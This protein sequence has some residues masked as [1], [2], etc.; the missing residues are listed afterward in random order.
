MS[1]LC[2]SLN[3]YCC[4]KTPQ[5]CEL[6][7]KNFFLAMINPQKRRNFSRWTQQNTENYYFFV[8]I[9]FLDFYFR[10]FTF[11]A[12]KNFFLELFFFY[13]IKSYIALPVCKTGKLFFFSLWLACSFS[14][15]FYVHSMKTFM[16]YK[17]NFIKS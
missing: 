15:L 13:F 1:S 10:T 6:L 4:F 16:L 17:A 8:L 2:L 11:A 12:P 7:K 14:D 3:Y 5:L 9:K